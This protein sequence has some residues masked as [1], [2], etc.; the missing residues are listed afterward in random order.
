VT[1]AESFGADTIDRTAYFRSRSR[2]STCSFRR[3][4]A[5]KG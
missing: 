5:G 2:L 4:T 3:R 1:I